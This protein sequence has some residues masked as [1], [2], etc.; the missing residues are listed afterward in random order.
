MK[1]RFLTLLL[2]IMLIRSHSSALDYEITSVI[3]VGEADFHPYLS[4]VIWSPDGTM[5]AFTKGGIIKVSD[6]LGNVRD[7]IKLDM[8]IHRWDWVSDKQI[9]VSMRK[10][11]GNG[12]ETEEELSLVNIL[13]NSKST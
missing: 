12:P 13:A 2:L 10:F 9:A 8:P 6:T 3:E 4:P 5:L 7:I 1:P 11:T